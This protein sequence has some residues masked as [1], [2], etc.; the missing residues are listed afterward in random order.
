MHIL[1]AQDK[2]RTEVDNQT[3]KQEDEDKKTTE[4]EGNEKGEEE[5]KSDNEDIRYD[6]KDKDKEADDAVVVEKEDND[7]K[8]ENNE[9]K[10]GEFISI[11]LRCCGK[12]SPVIG[13]MHSKH[14]HCW[15]MIGHHVPK[16]MGC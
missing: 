3:D 16:N 10:N 13:L 6:E 1:C 11:L 15:F 9:H 5:T 7:E 4:T 2:D 8:D 14:R 12:A